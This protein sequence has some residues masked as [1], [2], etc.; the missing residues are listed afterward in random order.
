MTI[1]NKIFIIDLDETLIKGQ[2]QKYLI[3]Y[4]RDIKTISFFKYLN[5]MLGFILYKISLY[6]NAA[7]LLEYSLNNFK[8]EKESNIY[9]YV[10]DFFQQRLKKYYFKYTT[11]IIK[12]IQNSGNRIIVLSAVIDPLVKKICNDLNIEEY[13]STKLDFNEEGIFT[14]NIIDKQN[15]GSNKLENIKRYLENNNIDEKDCIVLTDHI[16]DI[17]LIKYF[18]NSII[19]NPN[20]KMK[21]WARQNNYPIIYLDNNESI[22][23]IK[24]YIES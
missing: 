1:K 3:E 8:G 2:S 23:Y 15:Y 19:A 5:I 22:Q 17:A 20:R 16:S 14:G 10:D 9:K 24:H 11:E 18:K 6:K 12:M 4:L 7:H 21:K 13:V